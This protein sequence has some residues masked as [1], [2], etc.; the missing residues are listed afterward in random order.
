MRLLDDA[1]QAAKKLLAAIVDRNFLIAGVA[2]ARQS[3]GNKWRKDLFTNIRHGA[4]RVHPWRSRRM[5]SCLSGESLDE[6]FFII[7]RDVFSRRNFPEFS[8]TWH[9]YAVEYSLW[10]NT[11]TKGSVL[12]LPLELWHLSAGASMDWTYFVALRRLIKMYRGEIGM[13]YT[14]MGV[15]PT[16]PWLLFLRRT[17]GSIKSILCS[18]RVR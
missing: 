8:N 16:N 9:L 17:F 12:G 15:W 18:G 7:P 11:Q 13:I 14:P 3:E 5:D 4:E 6:C 10:A 1:Q 2:L